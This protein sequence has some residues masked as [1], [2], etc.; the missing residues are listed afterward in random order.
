MQI[1]TI[2]QLLLD[3]ATWAEEVGLDAAEAGVAAAAA[4]LALAPGRV[5]GAGRI[6]AVLARWAT[7]ERATAAA[8]A[9]A[10]TRYRDAA[11]RAEAKWDDE[12]RRFCLWTLLEGG[13]RHRPVS[14]AANVCRGRWRAHVKRRYAK[15]E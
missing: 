6:A 5:L 2:S 10:D 8:A 11:R 3:P 7:L 9:A 15:R 4:A 12:A 14:D 1:D 13:V